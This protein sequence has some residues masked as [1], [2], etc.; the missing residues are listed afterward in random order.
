M[1]SK[2]YCLI[3]VGPSNVGNHTIIHLMVIITNGLNLL[4][5]EKSLWDPFNVG[6]HINTKRARGVHGSD[7]CGLGQIRHQS[8]AYGLTDL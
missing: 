4:F 5:Y 7:W 2:Q 6:S 1:R 3:K 8:V